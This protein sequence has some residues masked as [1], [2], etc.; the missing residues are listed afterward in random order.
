M[1]TPHKLLILTA[2]SGAGKTT[3]VQHLLANC[4]ELAFSVSATTRARRPHEEEGR[5]YYFMDVPTF[6]E[7]IATGQFLEWEE[8]YPQQYYGTLHREVSRLWAQGRAVV[9]DIDVKG[10]LNIKAAYPADTL[11]I[12]VAPP[13][14]AT[15]LERLQNRQ[16][17]SAESLQKRLARAQ[18]ELDYRNKFDYILVNDELELAKEEALRVARTFL[19]ALPPVV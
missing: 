8:V 4:P 12:F 16:T 3:L 11:A 19:A 17:E 9:F 18:E 13:T 14:P 5:D 10:A 15:L 6:Q 1:A 7:H 2:P